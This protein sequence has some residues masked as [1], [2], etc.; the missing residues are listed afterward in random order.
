M[1]WVLFVAQRLLSRRGRSSGI[2]TLSA[3]GIAAGVM[4]LI[5]VLG[6]M[7]GFQR[8]TIESILE[9]GSFHLRVMAPKNADS[10]DI[11]SELESR[12]GIRAAVPFIEV[13]T[14]AHGFWPE[15]RG[16]LVR[17]IPVNWLER[18]E[19]ARR[20][21]HVVAG[22]F[23]LSQSGSVVLG[24]ELA[25]A[26]GVR[27]GDPVQLMYLPGSGGTPR[28][29]SF[30]VV[31]IV[32][33]GYLDYDR[34]WVLVSLETARNS[35]LV[36]GV[37]VVG[38]KTE[39]RTDREEIESFIS[40]EYP[41]ASIVDWE[42]YN[43][44]IFGALRV[45]KSMMIFLI[46]LIFIVVG[47]NIFQSLRR[48]IFE[49]AE[50]IAILHALGAPSADIRIVFVLEGVIIGIVGAVIGAALGLF[51]AYNINDVFR[52]AETA[53]NAV[54]SIFSLLRGIPTEEMTI[55]S[56]AYFYLTDVPVAVYAREV[57][58]VA[59]IAVV[60]SLLAA[61]IAVTRLGRY[62]P[63]EVLRDE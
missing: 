43:A 4:T 26:L 32:R 45:E 38:I 63:S 48:G 18:D 23:D 33:S 34:T 8:T 14:L 21:L 62:R 57:L 36:S 5:A 6:V 10:D 9:L 35:L 54:L 31:G 27:V 58:G 50:D 39:N 17:A 20:R 12:R 2:S 59:G 28:D 41:G 1:N 24:S 13:Q 56:P 29:A 7:N 47:T 55:F 42:E 16:V 60:S 51:I 44:G 11:A 46:G 61:W 49:R 37:P 53:V 25:V 22:S 40:N 3:L 30:Q 15:P 19:G 52:V